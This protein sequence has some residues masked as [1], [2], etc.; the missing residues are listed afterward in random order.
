MSAAN[1]PGPL[2]GRA[3]AGRGH[4]PIQR[5][6]DLLRLLAEAED[7]VAVRDVAKALDLPASTSHRLLRQFVSAGFV[8][9]DPATRRYRVGPVLQRL[10]AL[11]HSRADLAKTVQPYLEAITSEVDETS[12]F[13]TYDASTA[14]VAFI[15]KADCSQALSYRIHLNRP[16]SAYWGSS[17]RAIV[18]HLPESEVQRIIAA[19]GPSPVGRRAP[20]RE[21]QFRR[22]LE[23][24]RRRGY[25]VTRGQKLTGGIGTAAPVF[26]TTGVVGSIT[27]TVPEVRF[28]PHLGSPLQKL[29]MRYAGQLSLHLGNAT[30]TGPAPRLPA[31]E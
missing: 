15:A 25:A 30:A 2:G 29:V 22:H 11:I 19:A 5:A 10:A 18:A 3:D 1:L 6:A 12:F 9:A 31:A 21:D 28:G 13:T 14:S 24:I 17:S 16:Y 26:D 8:V 7:S 23:Q 4:G 20:L 27:V